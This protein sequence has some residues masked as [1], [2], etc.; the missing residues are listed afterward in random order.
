MQLELAMLPHPHELL[1]LPRW[2]ELPYEVSPQWSPCYALR[3]IERYEM[4]Y[5]SLRGRSWDCSHL[6]QLQLSR[7]PR[8][9]RPLALGIPVRSPMVPV[10]ARGKA[11]LLHSLSLLFQLLAS[12]DADSTAAPALARAILASV[13]NDGGHLIAVA[14]SIALALHTGRTDLCIQESLVPARRDA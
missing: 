14:A 10:E 4:V 1:Q 2:W 7:T 13:R 6:L 3:G 9:H 5:S 8:P 12:Q 11:P